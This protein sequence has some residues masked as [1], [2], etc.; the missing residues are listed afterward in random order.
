MVSPCRAG[1]FPPGFGRGFLGLVS[2][3]LFFPFCFCLWFR[4]PFPPLRAL[5]GAMRLKEGPA[6]GTL[7]RPLPLDLPQFRGRK[8]K[9]K[10]ER[11]IDPHLD[12]HLIM[13]PF[14][15]DNELAPGRSH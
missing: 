15:G 1:R 14:L 10:R 9:M 13:P 7:P 8:M 12:P 5:A 11:K 3:L 2:L 4:A 6:R